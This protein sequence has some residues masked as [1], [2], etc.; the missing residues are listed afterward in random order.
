LETESQ[1]FANFRL[2]KVD[3]GSRKVVKT[4]TSLQSLLYA[5]EAQHAINIR[6]DGLPQSMAEHEVLL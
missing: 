3:F 5:K 2:A 1:F 6:I 4:K